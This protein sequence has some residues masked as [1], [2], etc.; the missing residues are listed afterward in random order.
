[1]DIKKIRMDLHQIPELGKCEFQTKQYILNKLKSLDCEIY[2]IGKTGV[3]AYFNLKKDKTICFRADMDGLKIKEETNVEYKSKNEGFMHACGHDGH[4]A[5]L[6]G[7]AFWVNE[8]KSQIPKNI[9]CLFQ[10]SEEEG[11][12]ALD[13]L[14]SGILDELNVSEIYGLH[15][16][17]KLK[18][19]QLFT[20]SHALLASSAEV[21]LR[22]HGASVHAANRTDQSD[23]M[24]VMLNYI[25]DAYQKINAIE[26][27]HLLSFG[28]IHAGTARNIVAKEASAYATMRSFDDEIHMKMCKILKELKEDY[29][30]RSSVIIELE[31]NDIYRSVLNHES[32]IDK[33]K[34]LLSLNIL[35]E[36]FMQAEDFGCY[37]RKYKCMF[38]LLGSGSN[39]LLHTNTFDFNM[40]ILATGVEAYK[41]LTIN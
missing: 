23:A 31:I 17:P 1:M 28:V 18:E 12:G 10:P 21:N 19:N 40:D 9:V 6:L 20:K 3:V 7:Y 30:K 29:E 22:F 27:K 41:L 37:T 39:H 13:I 25:K 38:M 24:L 8:N 2:E 11:A 5:I 26:G 32:L 34:E 35:E 14:K 15:I 36:P 16:W 33:Y 4:M